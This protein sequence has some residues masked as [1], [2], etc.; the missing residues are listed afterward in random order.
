MLWKTKYRKPLT[1]LQKIFLFC[2]LLVLAGLVYMEA[3]KPQP[4]NWF[5][6]YSKKDKIPLGTYVLFDLLKNSFNEKLVEKD[7]PPFEVLQNSTLKGTYFFVNN[8]LDFDKTELDS[9]LNWAEKG[10]T[11]FVSANYFSDKLLDT[12]N[13][14][15]STEVNV[16][17]IGTEPLLKLVNKKF[18]SQKPFHI[19]KDLAVRYFSEID[20]VSQ[21]VLG[22][23]GA[24]IDA[25]EIKE[26]RVNFIKIP[27]GEGQFLLH[28]QPEIFSNY[29]LL[30]EEN[31]QH[32]SQVLAYI[33]DGKTLYWD[34]YYKS[35]KRLDISPLRVLLNNK[36]FKWAYYFVLIGVLL[37]IIFEGRRK[38]RSIPIVQPLT[39]KTY[40]YT[41]TI[42]GMYLDKKENHLIAQKQIA[43]FM[44]FVRTRLR[45]PTEKINERFYKAVA[46]RSGNTQEDTLKLFTFIEK[47]N[48]QSN[49]TQEELLKLYQEIKEFK[50]KTDG[51][52]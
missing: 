51:K 14:E 4:V 18:D 11:V 43:L 31:A 48:N 19:K 23:S 50:N 29:F 46:E 28:L 33:N 30:S 8:S 44:E 45:V 16:E 12:L 36:Y 3:T 10:N 2:F 9:L 47:V 5:P 20:T 39:N 27:M 37:F 22:V 52:S 6:S 34:N 32:T 25:L 41:R 35:G 13:L 15:T 26:P 24:Y 49:T 17:K 21:T 7:I 1:K 40:E 38:Q 42:A